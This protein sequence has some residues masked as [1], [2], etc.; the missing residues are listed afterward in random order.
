MTDFLRAAR[1]LHKRNSLLAK[2]HLTYPGLGLGFKVD[3][4]RFRVWSFG[5]RVEGLGFRV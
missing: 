2:A 1:N 3:G 5:F 4:L